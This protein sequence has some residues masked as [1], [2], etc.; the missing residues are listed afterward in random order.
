MH[1]I[2]LGRGEIGD[3]EVSGDLDMSDG[4]HDGGSTHVINE[5]G[6]GS[7][8]PI[9]IRILLNIQSNSKLNLKCC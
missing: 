8:M 1:Y 3:G 5:S 6:D 4:R 7:R 2:D 9:P